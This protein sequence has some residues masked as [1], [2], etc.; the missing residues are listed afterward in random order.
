MSRPQLNIKFDGEGEKE[1][2]EAVKAR[3]QLERISLKEF[4]LDA[5]KNRLRVPLST[6]SSPVLTK[7][8]LGELK[9]RIDD[10]QIGLMGEIRKD[11]DQIATLAAAIALIESRLDVLDPPTRAVSE[12]S[13]ARQY[14]HG[15]EEDCEPGNRA[16]DTW[17]SDAIEFLDTVRWGDADG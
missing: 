12:D 4:V 1:L 13:P 15:W 2:L 17:G 5:L 10:N 9:R 3:A 16:W 14:R 7:G 6:Q 8:E 11:R